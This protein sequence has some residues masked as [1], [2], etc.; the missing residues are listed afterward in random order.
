MLGGNEKEEEEE[1]EEKMGE[2]TEAIARRTCKGGRAAS[3][4]LL[5]L[6]PLFM[7]IRSASRESWLDDEKESFR[8]DMEDGLRVMKQL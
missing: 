6:L 8:F 4:G 7:P 3:L 2:G 1:E 5:L